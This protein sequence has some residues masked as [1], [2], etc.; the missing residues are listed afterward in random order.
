MSGFDGYFHLR[1]KHS[2]YFCNIFGFELTTSF[3]NIIGV[4]GGTI[5]ILLNPHSNGRKL[6]K[7]KKT[8]K[9]NIE[10]D[11]KFFSLVIIIFR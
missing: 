7:K 11:L 8:E 5:M 9:N 10:I 1:I 2:F 6:K 4:A 3:R